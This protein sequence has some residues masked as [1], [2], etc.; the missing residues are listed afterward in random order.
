MSDAGWRLLVGV[1][2]PAQTAREILASS[3]V[4]GC[5]GVIVLFPL[6]VGLSLW[7]QSGQVSVQLAEGQL[8]RGRRI[9][10]F[11]AIDAARLE[12]G[13]SAELSLILEASDGFGMLVPIHDGR[14]RILRGDTR[15]VL[16][17][18]LPQSSIV[19]STSP[20]DPKGRFAR[21]NFPTHLTKA[22][23]IALLENPP[24]PGD[25]LPVGS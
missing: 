5:L 25:P 4:D 9:M 14:K 3:F 1:T 20:Y 22:D 24:N 15:K 10:S 2:R 6:L 21:Y 16:L 12:G 13:P 11:T 7:V 18:I 23:A 17:Q 8:R 19:I